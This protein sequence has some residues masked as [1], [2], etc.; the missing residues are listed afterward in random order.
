MLSEI[1]ASLSEM[2]LLFII[3]LTSQSIAGLEFNKKLKR[4]LQKKVVSM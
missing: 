1:I 4:L 3:I 2:V